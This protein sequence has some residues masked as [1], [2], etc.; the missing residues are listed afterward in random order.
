MRPRLLAGGHALTIEPR[1]LGPRQ[2]NF[3]AQLDQ[4]R[5]RRGRANRIGG[6][7][8]RGARADRADVF[9]DVVAFAAVA[10]SDRTDEFPLLVNDAHRHAV[11]L[12]LDHHERRR[13][14]ELAGD[15]LKP[16]AQRRE[17]V[18]LG[19]PEHGRAMSGLGETVRAVVAH[20][21]KRRHGGGL[22]RPAAFALGQLAPQRIVGG[23]RHRGRGGLEIGVVGAGD[24]RAQLADAGAR[25]FG[26]FAGGFVR[27]HGDRQ[28]R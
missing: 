20:G 26:G 4:I 7:Q 8:R 12:R 19:Q 23:I 27:A 22:G 15:A 3:A 1:K 10:P 16:S 28:G 6:T 14:A 11:D 25:R 9:R 17:V 2:I 24:L 13:D 21:G 5:Q 18:G